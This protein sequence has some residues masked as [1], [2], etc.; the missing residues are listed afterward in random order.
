MTSNKHVLDTLEETGAGE[1]FSEEICDTLANSHFF[2]DFEY[3]ELSRL[4]DYLRAYRVK[5]GTVLYREGNKDAFL[6]FIISGKIKIL[7]TDAENVHKEIAIVRPGA[8]LGEMSIIDD[9]PH[10][11]SAVAI[12]ESTIIVLT[13]A[14]LERITEQQPKL[15]SKLLWKI[16]W[17][18]SVRLRQT[19]GQL[20]DHLS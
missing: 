2:K 10:S 8:T 7:K 11:A 1:A 20:V 12:E 17:Q 15:G 4:S 16:A 18:L 19:S 14:N 9:F 6:S 13:K 5:S 3:A